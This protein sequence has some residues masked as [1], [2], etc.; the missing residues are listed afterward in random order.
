MAST[1][2]HAP[3]VAHVFVSASALSR[4]Y[5]ADEKRRLYGMTGG[6][7]GSPLAKIKTCANKLVRK[8]ATTAKKLEIAKIM[9]GKGYG[10]NSSSQIG[11]KISELVNAKIKA[12]D[13]L[14]ATQE[15]EHGGLKTTKGKQKMRRI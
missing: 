12:N 2:A 5:F 3:P 6:G 7:S 9:R 10:V 14:V 8:I 11:I 13:D 15:S 4:R 1:F